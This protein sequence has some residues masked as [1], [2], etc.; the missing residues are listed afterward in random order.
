MKDKKEEEK[1][2]SKKLSCKFQ[3][4]EKNEWKNQNEVKD[5]ARALDFVIHQTSEEEEISIVVNCGPV[6]TL[7]T[8][9]LTM[10]FHRAV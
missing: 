5:S 10:Y 7:S 2:S 9:E 3:K 1:Q 6:D 4:H 8:R